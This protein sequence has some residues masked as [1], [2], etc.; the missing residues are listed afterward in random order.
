M[1]LMDVQI[2]SGTRISEL[3]GV[4]P[5]DI[6]RR[7]EGNE[8][9]TEMVLRDTKNGR[10]RVALLPVELGERFK[11]LVERGLPHYSAIRRAMRYARKTAGLP[12]TQPTHAH[13]HTTATRLTQLGR[14][15]AEVM[16]YLGHRSISTTLRYIESDTRGKRE[17]LDLLTSGGN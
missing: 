3:L 1:L 9:W 4:R 15:T 16:A 11:A 2:A 10:S 17:S 12:L 6:V 5:E 8:A 13:R 7:L 14:P